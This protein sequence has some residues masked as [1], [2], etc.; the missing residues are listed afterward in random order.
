MTQIVTSFIGS[1]GFA[2][3]FNV[4][5]KK[6]FWIG[7]GGAL[8][9]IAYLLG[10]HLSGSTFTALFVATAAVV[11]AAEVLARVIRVPVIML[12]V[13]MIIPLIPGSSLYYAMRYLIGDRNVA[14]VDSLRSLLIQSGAIALGL[15][16]TTS[17]MT[18]FFHFYYDRK[19]SL[20]SIKVRV[21]QDS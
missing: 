19:Q 12:L 5:G 1:A 9:W 10:L 3:L 11:A 7:C 17:A 20:A 14:F 21:T 4:R 16:V 8:S 15:I 18:N 6:L 2:L 13:P